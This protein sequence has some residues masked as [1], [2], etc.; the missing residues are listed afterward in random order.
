MPNGIPDP[1]SALRQL[2]EQAQVGLKQLGDT[3]ATG[4]S[5]MLGTLGAPLRGGAGALRLPGLPGLTSNPGNPGNPNNLGGL[6]APLTA[7][8]QMVSQLE[9]VAIP[10]G[11]PRPA[12]QLLRSIRGAAPAPTPAPPAE[13]TPTPAAARPTTGVSRMPQRPGI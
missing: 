8:L 6:L 3:V 1:F 2:G 11:M 10:R 4:A 9:E 12:A 13:P 7:P 5:Q